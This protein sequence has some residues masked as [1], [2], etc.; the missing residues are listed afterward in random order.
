MKKIIIEN[1]EFDVEKGKRLLKLKYN[2]CPFPQLESEWESIEPFTFEEI[3]EFENLE[4]RRV[5]ILCLGIERLVEEVNPKLLNSETITKT[6]TYIDENGELVTKTFED[7]YEL[8]EVEGKKLSKNLDNWRRVQDCHFVKCK[9]VSTEREYLIWVDIASVYRTNKGERE[10]F[11][12]ERDKNKVTAIQAIAWT[13]QTNIDEGN[14]KKIVRQGDCVL[15]K[16]KNSEL[17]TLATPRHLTEKEYRKLM[18][19]E[20]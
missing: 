16:P 10:W 12:A 20:S 8:Y 5:G 11:D 3:A 15:I 2:D 4:E 7:T 17:P 14:I 18:V 1:I 13:I 9:D 6:N 19:A